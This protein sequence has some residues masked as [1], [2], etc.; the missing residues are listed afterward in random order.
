M[1]WRSPQILM[2]L[3][4]LL[5]F[6]SVFVV[7]GQLKAQADTSA[8][9]LV[10]IQVSPTSI[11]V[12]SG[13][14]DI[15]VT[16]GFKDDSS[17][18]DSWS[19]TFY[20]PSGTETL[21]V[22]GSP[23][24]VSGTLT[25]GIFEGVSTLTQG[26]EEG[27]WSA[28]IVTVSDVDGNTAQ[29]DLSTHGV[30]L[31]QVGPSLEDLTPPD[32]VDISVS[33]TAV[34][35]TT[36]DGQ[37]TVQAHLTDDLSGLYR[38]SGS[39]RSPSGRRSA[40]FRSYNPVSGTSLDGVWEATAL[41]PQYTEP[42]MWRC[43]SLYVVDRVGNSATIDIEAAG[44]AMEVDVTSPPEDL[45]PPDVVNI[46]VSPTAVD[47]TAADGQVTV[48]AHVTDD[49]SGLDYLYGYLY[50]PS[51]RRSLY[52]HSYSPVSG[53]RLD[54]VWEATALFPRYTEPGVWRCENV[55]V[56]DRV[57]NIANIDLQAAGMSLEVEVTS[58]LED[59]A[60]PEL[61]SMSVSPTVLDISEG[62]GQLIV[63][64]H[65]TDDLCGVRR[66]NGKFHSPSGR[67]TVEFN[68]FTPLSGSRQ[69]GVWEATA[70]F[71]QYTE[72]GVW[73]CQSFYVVDRVGN[74]A[75]ID[76]QASG[77][78]L[79]LGI[80]SVP[81][82]IQ[83]LLNPVAETNAVGDSHTLT[84]KVSL[85]SL[86]LQGAQVLFEVIE[87]PHLGTSGT[88]VTD[89]NGEAAFTYTGTLAGTDTIIVSVD[90]DADG[91]VDAAREAT[92]VWQ[93]VT[94][95]CCL[96]DG[97]CLEGTED[98]CSA[99]GGTYQGDGT[100]C[101]SACQNDGKRT[102]CSILGDDSR[103]YA[104]DGDTFEFQGAKGENVTVRLESSPPECGSGKRAV[105]IL[106]SLGRGFPLFKRL[107]DALPLEMTV[108]LP[109]TGDYH[110]KVMESSGRAVIWGQKYEGDYCVT[111]EA[112]PETVATFVPDLDVE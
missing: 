52:L 33:P 81:P 70:L 69:D 20:S 62:D 51:G 15:T 107:N 12:S 18:V 47:V 89:D 97:S 4:F 101:S 29:I 68:S 8:P 28:S 87:G 36:A 41:F 24:L 32:L 30:F 99:E 88:E 80:I 54:G 64:V 75:N 3:G 71:P 84:A 9:T 31:I 42:G 2:G 14:E 35:V 67:R 19:V 44:M 108:T 78:P 57:G 105:L 59:M 17:G 22:E 109:V 60:P 45:T 21:P 7:S 6:F 76:L 48:Q 46:S 56:R 90:T 98:E 53:T 65:L 5:F 63:Q 77:L 93:E 27:I 23:G 10:S 37:V 112:S 1:R 11:D 85:D 39:F 91:E 40:S 94:G 34:N 82:E 96:P 106:R 72:P 111:L 103:Q 66:F 13:P 38:F 92:K 16:V 50:S 100:D 86:P 43:E 61:L 110:V 74:S 26:S 58:P 25:D 79:Q 104:A 55:Y 95:A 83:L 102:I 49:L 73:R